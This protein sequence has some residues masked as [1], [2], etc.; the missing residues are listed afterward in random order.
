M[1][2][3][4]PRPTESLLNIVRAQISFLLSSLN[5]DNFDRFQ[6]EIRS[7]CEQNG[8]E[9]YVGLLRR[10]I[11]ACYPRLASGASGDSQ[12]ALTLRLLV[13]E[14]QRLARDPFLADRLRDALE[15]GEGEVFRTLDLHRLLD[16]VPLR[17]LERLVL[18][19][20]FVVS[21]RAEFAS[22]AAQI[23]HADLENAV[24]AL[25]A[26]PSFESG[27]MSL[28][29]AAKLLAN[30]LSDPP[31]DAPV[32]DHT[33]RIA[34][35]TA[36]HAKYGPDNLAPVLRTVFP[37]LSLPPGTSLVQT[38]VQLGPEITA[39]QET[40]RA[41]L[42]RFGITDQAPPRDSQVVEIVAA[43]ARFAAEGKQLCDV[44]ALVRALSSF[45][46]PIH[47]AT[48]VVAFDR[49]ER[50]GVDTATL[51]LLIA[52][53]LNSPRD[54]PDIPHAVTGFWAPWQNP[55]WQLRLLDALLSLPNDTFNFVTLPGRRIVTVDDVAGASP[56]IKALA[57]NVQSHTWNELMLIE[58]LTRLG[59]EGT[60][61]VQAYVREMMD[62]AVKISA[63]LV[64]MGLLQVSKPW[65]QTQQ[66]YS[67][68]LLTMFLNGHPNHQLVFMRI[69]Q[70]EPTY[71]TK[72][73]GE[74]YADNALNI[75][76]ILDVAQD[77][78]I[79]DS[80][81]DVRPFDFALDVAAL[82]SRREYLNLDKWLADNLATHG[83]EFAHAV[84][85]F[86]EVK[87]KGEI[88][89]NS[90]G[91]EQAPESRTMPLNPQTIAIFIRVLKNSG[92]SLSP[93][94]AEYFV[95]IRNQC[96]QLHPRLMNLTPGSDAEPG[97]AVVSFPPDVEQ[98]VE[99][100]YKEMYEDKISIEQMIALLQRS[101]ASSNPRDLEV[102]ACTL[103][104][105][106]D[107]YRF[108]A[109][110]YPAR[111]LQMTGYLFGSLI[112]YRLVDYIPL[113][114]AIRYVLD[115]VRAPPDSNM[116]T[117][118]VNALNQFKG[119]LW[120]WKALCHAL[121]A[122]PHL[123]EA[124]PD[125][126]EAARRGLVA[127]GPEPEPAGEGGLGGEEE[128]AV[129]AFTALRPDTLPESEQTITEPAEEVSDKILFIVNNL[130]PSNFDAKLEE[131][132][133]RFRAEYAHWFARYLVVERVSLE[134]NNQGLYMRL[135]DGLD[136]DDKEQDK[137]KTQLG[138][139]I[140]HETYIHAA[141]L[142]NAEK[143]M[144]S[145]SERRV[146]KNLASWLGQLTL[147]RNRPILHRNLSFK[148]L[149]LEGF[150]TDRLIVAIPFV[151]AILEQCA[152]SRVFVPPNPWL[153]AVIGLLAEFY[154]FAELKLNLKFEI[155][156]LCK[157]LEVDL[158]KVEATSLLR[159][160]AAGIVDESGLPDFVQDGGDPFG[161]D[162]QSQ[163][164]GGQGS[165]GGEVVSSLTSGAGSSGM[166]AQIE[167]IVANLGAMV[168]VSPAVGYA[169]HPG[170]KRA[171]QVAIENAV[172]EIIL[173]VVDRSVTIAS[174]S[175]KEL[176]A[177]DYALE[178]D[179]MKVRKAAQQMVQNLAG[180]LALV[181]CK[182]PLKN[183]MALHIRQVLSEVG[184]TDL[185]VPEQIILRV[186]ADNV[187]MSCTAIERA[188]MDR[189]VTVIDEAFASSYEL[190]RRHNE[191]RPNQP[192]WDPSMPLT[193]YQGSLPDPLRIKPSGLLTQQT[194]VYDDF[195]QPRRVEQKR[196]LM[197]R[198]TSYGRQDMMTGAG[199]PSSN[200]SNP[201]PAPSAHSQGQGQPQ[202]QQ[203][204]PSLMI[205][206]RAME[207]FVT[208]I[209]ELESL[210][211]MAS[212]QH[213]EALQ[214]SQEIRI[215][216]RQILYLA[217]Q[218]S[219]REETALA[220]SQKIVQLLYKSNSPLAREVYVVIL[221]RLCEQSTKVAKEAT[222]WLL[223]AEDDRKLNVPVTTTLL[224][225]RLIGLREQD[226]QLSKL[227]KR[228]WR[229][230]V[231]EFTAKL[232]RECISGDQA[233]AT[234]TDFPRSLDALSHAAQLSK[235]PE[236]AI[237]LLEEFQGLSH[238]P[239]SQIGSSQQTP[240]QTNGHLV[241]LSERLAVH[242]DDW[243]RIF[244]RSPSSEKAFASYV[245]Q[246]TNEGI[247]KGEDIS[248]FFFRVCTETSVDQWSKYTA[249]GDIAA[250]FQPI[251]ALSRLIVLMIKYNGD[252]TD[253]PAKVHYLTKILSIVVLVLA[254]AHEASTEFPQ[255][256]PFFRFFSS[257]LSDIH[258]LESHLPYFPL[259]VAICDTF[260]TLQPTN[261]PGFA[262]SWM[263]LISHRLFMPKMLAS[264]NREGWRPYHRLLISLF[265]FLEPFLRAA[266]L[267]NSTRTLFH[268]ALRL[269]MVLLHDFP[270]FLSEFYFSLCDVIPARCIQMRNIILS[271][272]PPTLRLPDP[273]LREA[274]LESLSDMGPIP[275]VLSDFTAG[276]RHGD[277]RAAL[278][279]CLLNRG[280]TALVA[281]LKE[282][283]MLPASSPQ[284]ALGEHYNLATLNALVMYVGVSSV[285]QAKARSGSPVFVPT[286][287][288]VTLLTH[289]ATELDVEGQHHL[290]VSMVTHL[291]YPNAHTH[292][293]SSL[294]LH[295]FNEVK[296]T[297]LQEIATRVLL[298]RLMV[299]RPHPWGALV[300]FIELLRNPRY[301][302]W[303]K[304]FVRVAPEINMLL[305]R[306]PQPGVDDIVALLLLF[307]SDSVDLGLITVTFG[308]TELKYAYNNVLK[309]YQAVANH[310]DQ[311]PNDRTR[312]P[313]FTSRPT[314]CYGA[315]NPLAGE[316]QLAEYFHGP[317]GLSDI[318]TT[319][320]EFDVHDN[321]SLSHLV[322]ESNIP[323]E[324]AIINM[325]LREPDDSVTLIAVGPLTNIARAWLKEPRAL[326]RARRI[327]VMG[328]ALDAPGNTS[329][330]A[331]FN[332]FA[333]P[334]DYYYGCSKC[335]IFRANSPSAIRATASGTRFTGFNDTLAR[336]YISF[337][338]PS[339]WVAL[340]HAEI[341]RSAALLPGWEVAKRD[342]VI[343]CVGEY[344]RGMCVVDRR[345][346]TDVIGG[347]RTKDGIHSSSNTTNV[348]FG[349]TVLNKSPGAST[350]DNE[351][352]KKLF[353]DIDKAI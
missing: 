10:L 140:L 178:A 210:F 83:A 104:T 193:H 255:Q 99:N 90:V 253:I 65:N 30:L 292:W 243:V 206:E 88:A 148:D 352:R 289:L 22:A 78:K 12:W 176:V 231:M 113:G 189:A 312:F 279:Q 287:A 319:H 195:S 14:I 29:Q 235:A 313:G 226:L 236:E 216:I 229:P 130:A 100:I 28:S 52:I 290:L 201:S 133:T 331:E 105:L 335:A 268:G 108:F 304:D 23:V 27:D 161:F 220:F 95:E 86:L 153:M 188:A 343:E 72:A 199:G 89:R 261:F 257:L 82:A 281:S 341:P 71:L 70:I 340:V 122:I 303:S 272:Y 31:P 2:D 54:V 150:D 69:W 147:A 286:D 42:T 121:L 50:P 242:F 337:L 32:L 342:F 125:L 87:V 269:L 347:V 106:F 67:S 152:R 248:S 139:Y 183:N 46:T 344:T 310:I 252:A 4:T 190:R 49:L 103:H 239:S 41:L 285:A 249:A 163:P 145:S 202:A 258:G 217:Q 26:R 56:T 233:F 240:D 169:N 227:I 209:N 6:L 74:Y 160:R 16:R 305:E 332:F 177:K 317:D 97:V 205:P 266:E 207:R 38:L 91:G 302:F 19:S 326:A 325:L 212:A 338:A 131:M 166:T 174:I 143:T 284:V 203:S 314:L 61:E 263:T 277:L 244:Q 40:V 111:E 13:Q 316:L 43:L 300:T 128:Q 117:F 132:K 94:D 306:H 164:Q 115:A 120:E 260:N 151:C 165:S 182:E 237:S 55:L 11:A 75:T 245:M 186:V 36:A 276:L 323:A 63:E 251:D 60:P 168:V 219:D 175:T 1:N 35:L 184:F 265:R 112:Q 53:L 345:G 156:V 238:T 77:L 280:S 282:H 328:G 138:K 24:L 9:S 107:E 76:R 273:H 259:L 119:R 158:D 142:L 5:E 136:A 262:F 311:Y 241:L 181:T 126:A 321:T 224:Q 141:Q 247:L 134:A 159:T 318:S 192:F 293:F 7:L 294:L 79:L 350:L 173:P 68:K 250:A 221:G 155:E 254:H 351:L 144:A 57:A 47:W 349:V 137:E 315:A 33:E 172:R 34:L 73:F 211:Q 256:K 197:P 17:P 336:V 334:G 37:T 96:L 327:V 297:R 58:T 223:Y 98:E 230:I 204:M 296:N 8:A 62:K 274:Q 291:R 92:I 154:H 39:D 278:D 353:W 346:G 45:P 171:V 348:F 135:L 264:E 309:T 80:L 218:S 116:F 301:D 200:F 225:S 179:E 198:T 162:G 3:P 187:D 101:K 20:V 191:Q 25:C 123:A 84:I 232:I 64:Y 51:K 180:S 213:N 208:L 48:A 157:A 320:P 298:E 214:S 93:E 59:D 270:E 170:F 102:F 330:T 283:L 295:M 44:G 15:R 339:V 109:R 194:R 329:A 110:Y 299:F 124:R 18:A 333:D 185:M 246:L 288:G 324:D 322:N 127:E 234:R 196:V 129:V 66:E 167:A 271:A 146:L 222:D 267:Q 81:L 149:L 275:P 228:D 114:I 215:Y 118:G 85:A 308:N 307:A 21:S